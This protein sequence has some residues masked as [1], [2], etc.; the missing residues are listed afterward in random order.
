MNGN[1]TAPAPAPPIETKNNFMVGHL[2]STV[3]I[4]GLTPRRL[5]YDEA[6][7]LAAWL[8]AIAD[9]PVAF[10]HVN[11]QGAVLSFEFVQLL[12]EV[13]NT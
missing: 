10:D 3:T 12:R 9:K 11:V 8:V 5:T 1:D 6:L 7:N 13:Q 4:L 2:E